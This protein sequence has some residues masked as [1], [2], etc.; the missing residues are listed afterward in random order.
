MTPRQRPGDLPGMAADVSFR[1]G[2][3]WWVRLDPTE[4]SKIRKT[5]PAV[6]LSVDA[7]NTARRTIIVVPLSTRPSANPPL[8]VPVPSIAKGAMAICDQMRAVDK[9]RALRRFGRIGD[10]EMRAVQAGV[11]A[12]LGLV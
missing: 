7:V 10:G 9:T 2:D 11:R 4:G 5:R 1:R 6:I 8:V 3:V 12:V